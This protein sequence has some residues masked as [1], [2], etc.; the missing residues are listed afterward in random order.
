M[1]NDTHARTYSDT[2]KFANCL[3]FNTI[4]YHLPKSRST[5]PMATPRTSA[6]VLVTFQSKDTQTTQP[7]TPGF[8]YSKNKQT[9]QHFEDSCGAAVTV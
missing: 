6:S 5:K 8:S 2:L 7:A 3:H 9:N 4:R 1:R